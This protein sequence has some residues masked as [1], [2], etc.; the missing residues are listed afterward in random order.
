MVDQSELPFR[1]LCRAHGAQ[2][3]YTPM[4]HARLFLE[5]KHYRAEHF[6]TCEGDR[7]LFVQ[8]CAND[9]D[10]FVASAALVQDQADYIDL[11]LGCPQRIA[12]RGFYG[13]FLMD[14]QDLVARLVSAAAAQLSTPVSVK[15][16][17]F[18]QLA[19]TIAYATMLQA[20]GASL[21]A[22]HGR[23][24]DM[25][26]HAAHRA[27]WE[28][29]AAVR[30]ALRIPLLANGDVR[31][32]AEAAALME[33]TG[34][35]GVMSAEPLLMNPMLF[36]AAMQPQDGVQLPPLEGL[37]ACEEY[38]QQC[39]Q[40]PTHLRM[41]RGHVHK[42]ITGWLGE[43]PEIRNRMHQ[44]SGGME[45]SMQQLRGLVAE[46][47]QLVAAAGRDKP[48]PKLPERKLK[49]MER[50]AAKAAAIAEQERE[51]AAAGGSSS[52]WWWWVAGGDG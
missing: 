3:A 4:L 35:D 16:R 27:D 12:K 37:R 46:L 40:Y 30:A 36:D 23:T 13:A 33:S 6:T 42:L 17:L 1:M 7:P 21:L 22:I 20:A 5:H 31:C 18:P 50:E 39:E 29:I 26:D 9:P 28:A 49:A 2:A 19:D 34:A 47:R 14:H 11:N 38:L 51:A 52:S 15:I 48:V 8:F 25:K 45:E 41:V 44:L 10:I 43:Y 32:L 24:R